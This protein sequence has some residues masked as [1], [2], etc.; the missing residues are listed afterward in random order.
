MLPWQPIK[1]S[2]LDKIHKII[3]DYSKNISVKK[4]SKYLQ[5]DSK[6]CQFPLFPLL[7]NGK[8]S[9]VFREN[10]CPS[11]PKPV[12]GGNFSH[13]AIDPVWFIQACKFGNIPSNGPWDNMQTYTSWLNFGKL[14][15]T[16][17]LKIRS[18]SPK[19]IQLLI[20][21]KCYI[22]ANLVKIRQLVHEILC[23][24]APSGSNLA[25]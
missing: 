17:T 16:V 22:H 8:Y 6:N 10:R 15:L 11:P 19:P 21:S 1:F 5:W 2:D 20:M 9:S 12:Y 25:V 24:Q 13:E 14:S 23:T 4:K 18:R 3:K 7:V